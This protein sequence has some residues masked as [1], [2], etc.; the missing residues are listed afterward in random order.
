MPLGLRTRCISRRCKSGSSRC[1]SVASESAASKLQSPS[2]SGAFRSALKRVR[3]SVFVEKSG[4]RSI[5]VASLTIPLTRSVCKS[6]A[7]RPQPKSAMD[8]TARGRCFRIC[9]ARICQISLSSMPVER[10]SNDRVRMGQ[11]YARC[12]LVVFGAADRILLTSG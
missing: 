4:S 5:P 6:G 11:V 7:E 12:F 10:L 9:E 2:A 8:S 3:V 1:S